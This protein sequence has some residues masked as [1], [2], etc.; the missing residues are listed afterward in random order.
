[1]DLFKES[2]SLNVSSIWQLFSVSKHERNYS[3]RSISSG[4]VNKHFSI[5]RSI[6]IFQFM[7][8]FIFE[9][10]FVCN[11]VGNMFASI[12]FIREFQISKSTMNFNFMS[13]PFGSGCYF[14]VIIVIESKSHVGSFDNRFGSKMDGGLSDSDLTGS[15]PFVLVGEGPVIFGFI[16][17]M[18]ENRVRYNSVFNGEDMEDKVISEIIELVSVFVTEIPNVIN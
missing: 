8:G 12:L 6:V 17:F 2:V 18:K 1:L 5:E 13:V 15:L 16:V 14:S 10:K 3:S 7:F 9:G 4:V 11:E